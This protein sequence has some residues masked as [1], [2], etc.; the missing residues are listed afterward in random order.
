MIENSA[1]SVLL[2]MNDDG[3]DGDDGDDGDDDDDDLRE[4]FNGRHPGDVRVKVGSERKF[5]TSDKFAKT[6]QLSCL[7]G[8]YA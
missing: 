2:M 7:T 8:T 4:L 6:R 3:G 1:T 5:V